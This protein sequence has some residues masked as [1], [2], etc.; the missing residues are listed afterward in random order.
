MYEGMPA[1]LKMKKCLLPKG[2]LDEKEYH[3]EIIKYVPEEERIYL[4]L[5]NGELTEISLDSIYLCNIVAKGQILL[6]DGIIKERYK[7]T[8]GNICV[9]Q[10]ENGFYKY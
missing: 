9:L 4:I 10:V 1:D 5:R 3:F 2:E 6:C 7:N 8:K